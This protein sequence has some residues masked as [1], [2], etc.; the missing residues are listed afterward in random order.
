VKALNIDFEASLDALVD[1]LPSL[2]GAIGLLLA[3]FIVARIVSLFLHKSIDKS[4]IGQAANRDAFG[5]NSPSLGKSLGSAAFWLIVLLF[6]PPVLGIL[7]FTEALDP[8]N[9]MLTTVLD[10]LPRIAGASFTIVIGFV[11]ATVA[12]RATQS[13][14]SAA[15]IDHAAERVAIGDM[16]KGKEIARAA[17]LIVFAV[18]LIPTIIAGLEILA[19]KS[20]SEPAT[21]MLRE[22]L[23]A[24]PSILVAALFL[25]IFTIFA[26]AA[27]AFMISFLSGL[28]FDNFWRELGGAIASDST[29]PA[30]APAMRQMSPTNIVANI[31][32]AAVLIIGAIT[33]AEQ[34]NIK[35]VSDALGEVLSVAGKILLGSVIILVG[36]PVSRFVGNTIRRT[37]DARSELVATI[38]QWGIIVLVTAIGV[39]EMGLGEDII[40]AG[41]VLILGA[42]CVAGALAFGIGGRGAAARL[43]ERLD[44]ERGDE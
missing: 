27:R 8:V 36:I 44:R 25:F 4:R 35:P 39:R 29:A 37:D 42:A 20:I 43:L 10:Y 30:K 2:F 16:I 17:G 13:L 12:Q 23:K 3:A 40:Y 14:I 5:P 22:M 6:I 19:I 41:F 1:Y 18:I 33:A 7:G 31:V 38:V 9:S 15:P 21:E 34:L 26:R 28:G 11:I 32:M 24:I